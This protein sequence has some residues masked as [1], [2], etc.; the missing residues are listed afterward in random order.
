MRAGTLCCGEGARVAHVAEVHK[1]RTTPLR[2]FESARG[3]EQLQR[4]SVESAYHR[5]WCPVVAGTRRDAEKLENRR[6]G[7]ESDIAS[8]EAKRENNIIKTVC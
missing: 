7:A 8:V 5:R 4:R 6:K 3:S 1:A 2:R